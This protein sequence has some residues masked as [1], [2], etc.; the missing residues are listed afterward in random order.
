MK[1]LCVLAALLL[2]VPPAARTQS[3]KDKEKEKPTLKSVKVGRGTLQA[4]VSAT[5]TLQPEEVIDVGASFGGTLVKFGADPRDPKKTI[6]Y[7][8]PVEEGTILA[9]LDATVYRARVEQARARIARAE[10]ESRLTDVQLRQAELVV[11]RL[12]KVGVAISAQDLARARYEFDIAR[13][14]SEVQRAAIKEAEAGLQEAELNLSQTV[15]RSPVKG[16]IIDR[17]VNLGQ[18]VTPGTNTSALFVIA[19][20]LKK[21]QLWAQV[22][23]ADVALVKPG[24]AGSFKVDTY[25]R[26]AFKGTVEQVRLNANT[27]RGA[28]TYTVVIGVENADGKLLPYLS[29]DVRIPAA[30][31]KNVLLVPNSAL[32]WLPEAHQ[33]TPTARGLFYELESLRKESRLKR[34]VWAEDKG[35]VRPIIIRAGLSD[36][37]MTEVV[38]GELKEGASIVVGN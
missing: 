9:H 25:P 28:V 33:V 31:K 30:E 20:D 5:G 1:R 37:T 11:N 18:T 35:Y 27:A 10:S 8:T 4:S 16:I 29:T 13:A 38:D 2:A 6:D 24:Q 17:R 36:G 12:E 15:I 14:Q 3:G 26:D 23:E 21:M 34:V 7:N 32:N 19:R 22:H